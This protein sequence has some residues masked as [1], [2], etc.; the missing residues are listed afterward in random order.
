MAVTAKEITVIGK[1]LVG[2]FRQRGHAFDAI[3]YNKADF[4]TP[5]LK[6]VAFKVRVGDVL[7]EEALEPAMQHAREMA[8][9]SGAEPVVAIRSLSTIKYPHLARKR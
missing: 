1:E 8:L 4:H 5:P 9:V 3:V 6:R 7:P 2:T